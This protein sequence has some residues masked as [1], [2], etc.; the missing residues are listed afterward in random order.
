MFLWDNFEIIAWI[1]IDFGTKVPS[2][3]DS[4]WIWS[5]G[6]G[7]RVMMRMGIELRIGTGDIRCR[8][9]QHILINSK[10]NRSQLLS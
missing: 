2:D 9:R 3:S 7:H 5:K 10:V 1:V 8:F 4:N 6:Q